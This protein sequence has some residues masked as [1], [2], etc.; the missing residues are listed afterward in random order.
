MTGYSTFKTLAAAFSLAATV[1]FA[2]DASA[3]GGLTGSITAKPQ[4]TAPLLELARESVRDHR[5]NPAYNDRQGG[6][7]R[8]SRPHPHVGQK[9]PPKGGNVPWTKKYPSKI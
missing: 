7:G 1:G 8:P 3:F 5:R 2:A 4:N 6:H 9:T